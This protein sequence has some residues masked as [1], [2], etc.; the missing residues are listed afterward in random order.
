MGAPDVMHEVATQR[1]LILGGTAEA[2]EL[3]AT[4]HGRPG[5][6][7]MSSLAGRVQDPR[8]PVGEVRV[9][10]FGGV[11]GLARWLSEHHVSALVD[12][13]HPYAERMHAT[14]LRAAE[15][16]GVAHLRLERPGW[17][18]SA[19]DRWT[20]VPDFEAAA[21][22]LPGL[23]RRAFLTTGRQRLDAFTQLTDLWLLARVVDE[24]AGPLPANMRVIRDR[25]PYTVDSE[26]AL[27][28]GHRVDV[29]VTKDSGGD[30]TAAKLTAARSLGLP[31][32]MIDRPVP[33]DAPA[34]VRSVSAAAS[35]IAGRA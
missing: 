4:L 23:G 22:A 31:V 21:V 30:Y 35:W 20:R 7:V 1:V 29:V 8:L 24:P 5:L 6:Q 14:A 9:G 34:V 25:G 19:A 13:T 28:T 3:A 33:L 17:S 2:R 12:A 16:T 10:G 15:L 32:L 11:D 27:L 26:T 18:A